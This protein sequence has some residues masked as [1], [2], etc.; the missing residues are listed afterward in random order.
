MD[1]TKSPNSWVLSPNTTAMLIWDSIVNINFLISFF[2]IP[3]ILMKPSYLLP[4]VWYLE[5]IIDIIIFSDIFLNFFTAYE[6][7]SEVVS[8]VKIVM[9][10][11]LSSYFIFD[12]IST[13]P[14]LFT[15]EQVHEV[16]FL[17]LFRYVQFGR[18][19]DLL[20]N[21][22]NKLRVTVLTSLSSG[23]IDGLINVVKSILLL[24]LLIHIFT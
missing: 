24:F 2:F 16:Y 1:K 8:D 12:F 6:M 19:L 9:V 17:K 4:E 11:Y 21:V 22:L 14:G 5:L 15:G 23:L 7:E 13:A 10:T 18:L 20:N 3:F